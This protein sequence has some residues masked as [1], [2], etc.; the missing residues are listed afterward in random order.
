MA[1]RG[2]EIF[3]ARIEYPLP[4]RSGVRDYVFHFVPASDGYGG[5]ARD[6]LDTFYPHHV[7][8]EASS[9]EAM[10]DALYT[11]VTEHGVTQIRELVMVAHG[12]SQ[13]LILPVL[14]AASAT[15]LREY[16]YA[17]PPSFA[18]LQE[19]FDLGRFTAFRDRRTAVVA[20]LLDDSWVT[21][22]ACRI[23]LSDDAMYAFYSFFGGR[24]NVYGCRSSATAES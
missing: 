20:R 1:D 23:G 7:R 19:D 3:E 24:A 2:R 15:E 21:I 12:T 9:L 8:K 4:A 14:R 5:G 16:R 18:F 17:W 13:G 22:R 10:I 11:D 6:F